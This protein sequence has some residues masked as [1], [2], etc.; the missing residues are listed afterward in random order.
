MRNGS[1]GMLSPVGE[2]EAFSTGDTQLVANDSKPRQSIWKRIVDV[3]KANL[4]AEVPIGEPPGIVQ[5][6]RAII[7]DSCMSFPVYYSLSF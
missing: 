1:P 3:M 2:N 6:I 4:K 5:S 7:T